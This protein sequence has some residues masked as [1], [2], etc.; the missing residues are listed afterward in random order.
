MMDEKPGYR[1]RSRAGTFER[2]L[3]IETI[4]IPS[5]NIDLAG[6]MDQGHF[7][8]GRRSFSLWTGVI[9]AR[10]ELWTKVIFAGD[11]LDFR[12][13]SLFRGKNLDW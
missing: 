2:L 1:P 8:Y 5:G 12:F 6:R 13:R 9:F 4:L 10:A 11:D 7:D 3:W